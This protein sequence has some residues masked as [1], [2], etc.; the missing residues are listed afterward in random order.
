SGGGVSTTEAKPAYQAAITL[1]TRRMI[2][3][4][5]FDASPNSGVAVLDSYSQ[6]S[7]DP[8]IAVGGTS[9]AT[10][11]WAGV[12][13]V[14]DQGRAVHG[15]TSLDGSSQTIP[16]L[17][18]LPAADF[19][20]IT[21]GNNGH[22]AGPGYD[23]VTGLG[24]PIVS[25]VT[26]GLIDGGTS[27]PPVV[28]P[29]VVPPPAPPPPPP[30]PPV[31]GTYSYAAAGLPAPVLDFYTTISPVTVP[32]D[33]NIS[34]LT[35]T[36]NITHTYDSD[37][38][39]QLVSPSGRVVTL[40]NRDGG[41][42]HNYTNTV[43]DSTST[44]SVTSGSAPFSGT[45]S[46]VGSLG[47]FNSLDAKGTWQLRVS[48][49]ARLDQGTLNSWTLTIQGTPGTAAPAM[50]AGAGTTAVTAAFPGVQAKLTDPTAASVTPPPVAASPP[51][52]MLLPPGTTP[53]LASVPATPAPAAPVSAPVA[54]SVALS[55]TPGKTTD[56]ATPA[57]IVY[58]TAPTPGDPLDLPFG[59]F[60]G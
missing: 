26:T 20:D 45:Y 8:W 54:A 47:V 44:H 56:A 16:K 41:A 12:I 17:Y 10:P 23:L 34:K 51:A 2:P 21:T 60:V 59:I 36:L 52:A 30:P 32:T 9:L 28:P 48:D 55:P 11:L 14:A 39:V 35:V 53:P 5:A 13:A 3:D 4:V 24:T 22:A 43:F 37:L 15:Q 6:G 58:A 40:A 46:P 49:V 18:A 42:G 27:P 38:V 7:A 25:L 29:P 31:A 33:I 50:V 1:G 57:G 19:H